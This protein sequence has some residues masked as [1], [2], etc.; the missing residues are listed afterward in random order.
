M[1]NVQLWSDLMTEQIHAANVASIYSS[2]Y[3]LIYF[4]D[5]LTMFFTFI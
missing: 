1:Y 5:N 3:I 4:M 2:L